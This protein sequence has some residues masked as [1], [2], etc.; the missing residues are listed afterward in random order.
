MALNAGIPFTNRVNA[1]F[2]YTVAG[3]YRATTYGKVVKIVMQTLAFC[4]R[5]YGDADA[6]GEVR[7]DSMPVL[8]PWQ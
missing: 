5:R 3:A 6:Q 2:S 7:R 1:E 4:T 8:V